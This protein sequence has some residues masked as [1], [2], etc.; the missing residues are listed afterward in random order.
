MGEIT[1]IKQ[2]RFTRGRE[3][4][5]G[6]F[7]PLESQMNQ[8]LGHPP[9]GFPI[10]GI[11]E[12]FPEKPSLERNQ[13]VR[14]R[15]PLLDFVKKA[16]HGPV[17]HDAFAFYDG[18][19]MFIGHVSRKP[20]VSRQLF[21]GRLQAEID[22]RLAMDHQLQGYRGGGVDPEAGVGQETVVNVQIVK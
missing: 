8:R 13:G 10:Q 18:S 17:Q 21:P 5:S 7:H 6:S 9:A 3:M 12:H 14:S 19:I 22:D 11:R 1:D 16:L 20:R 15:Q 4:S 2:T